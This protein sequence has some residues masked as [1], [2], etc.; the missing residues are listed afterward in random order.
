MGGFLCLFSGDLI[1]LRAL[2][3]GKSVDLRVFPEMLFN[4]LIAMD[5]LM[6]LLVSELVLGFELD[7]GGV[8]ENGG[9][10]LD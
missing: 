8:F 2:L 5:I 4:N 10:L 7:D 3:T 6:K 1:E 9:N